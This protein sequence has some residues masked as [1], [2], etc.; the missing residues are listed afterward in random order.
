MAIEDGTNGQPS[1]K[2]YTKMV[3]VSITVTAP[4]NTGLRVQATEAK[5]STRLGQC[6]SAETLA[7]LYNDPD[8]G[9]VP[10]ATCD[11][12]DRVYPDCIGYGVVGIA[13]A[14]VTSSLPKPWAVYDFSEELFPNGKDYAVPGDQVPPHPHT[15]NPM[16][17]CDDNAMDGAA[18]ALP[19]IGL[20][21]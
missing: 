2:F 7:A 17:A 4:P 1:P 6:G 13:V 20:L 12:D 10:V 14:V 5:Y 3:R 19:A 9:S 15:P 18:A 21:G 16:I 8:S 11:R